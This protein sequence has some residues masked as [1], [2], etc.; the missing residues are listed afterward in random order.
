LLVN[1]VAWLNT[2]SEVV[3]VVPSNCVSVEMKTEHAATRYESNSFVLEKVGL[4]RQH[5]C[6]H[7]GVIVSTKTRDL[8]LA[9]QSLTVKI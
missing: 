5:W 9:A 1:G 4:D 7:I 8:Q 3:C 6:D 2:C